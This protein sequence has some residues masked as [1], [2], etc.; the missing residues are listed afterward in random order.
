MGWT[1]RPAVPYNR[2]HTGLRVRARKGAD[3]SRVTL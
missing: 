3:V 1:L 2:P